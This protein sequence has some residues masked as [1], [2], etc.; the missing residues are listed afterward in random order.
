[1]AWNSVLFHQYFCLS[2]WD[3]YCLYCEKMCGTRS[4]RQKEQWVPL[5]LSL[6]PAPRVPRTACTDGISSLIQVSR[7]ESLEGT[8]LSLIKTRDHKSLLGS[9]FQ[10]TLRSGLLWIVWYKFPPLGGCYSGKRCEDAPGA[11]LSLFLLAASRKS[12]SF[13][14]DKQEKHQPLN[15]IPLCCPIRAGFS[16]SPIVI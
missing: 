16:H 2:L 13:A 4:L 7:A 1:M 12:R 10:T 6:Q 5:G 3:C 15:F 14:P 9:C 8:S 11:G